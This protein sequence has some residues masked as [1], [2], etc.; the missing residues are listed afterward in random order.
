MYL[1][2]DQTCAVEEVLGDLCADPERHLGVLH[3]PDQH[4]GGLAG[5]HDQSLGGAPP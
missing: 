3:H 4:L 5:S 1:C 2:R